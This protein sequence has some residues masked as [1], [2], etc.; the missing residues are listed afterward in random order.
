MSLHDM[1]VIHGQVATNGLISLDVNVT[2]FTPKVLP[3]VDST[4]LI[5]PFWA[6]ADTDP[7]FGTGDVFYSNRSRTNQTQLD[8]SSEII[9]TAF[10][11]ATFVT[12]HLYIVTWFRV[13]YFQRTFTD[14]TTV[15]NIANLTSK[16]K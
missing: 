5:A 14:N 8:R 4:P 2:T 9:N 15:R 10:V 7:M 16:I 12:Q 3:T 11:G 1:S 6:D 13:G